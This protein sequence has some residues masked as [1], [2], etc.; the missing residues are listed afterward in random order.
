MKDPKQV[1]TDPVAVA[2]A[3]T[4]EL[5]TFDPTK[6]P[7]VSN[8]TFAKIL[9][10]LHK[11]RQKKAEEQATVLIKQLMTE[12]ETFAKEEKAFQS[13]KQA[14]LKQYNKTLAKV[15][16]LANGQPEP[17]EETTEEKSE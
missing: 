7:R 13:R 15:K 17:V 2:M 14:W 16:A 8:D 5:L 9:E 3:A 1:P 4:A 10:D 12:A 6:N 11:E